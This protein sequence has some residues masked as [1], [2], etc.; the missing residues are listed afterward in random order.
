MAKT[1]P[2]SSP[3][4]GGFVGARHA[5]LIQASQHC[6]FYRDIIFRPSIAQQRLHPL[7][8]G[9]YK[10]INNVNYKYMR[11][12]IILKKIIL[13]SIILF[14]ITIR[15]NAQVF[16]G[17]DLV[18]GHTSNVEDKNI[19]W[20]SYDSTSTIQADRI[21]L[22][23]IQGLWK[24]YKGIFKYDDNVR[25]IDISKPFIFEVKDNKARRSYN[26]FIPF[27]LRKNNIVLMENR[28]MIVG[29]INKISPNEMTITWENESLHRYDR[30]FYSKK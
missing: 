7:L 30:Y 22:K 29:I 25:T 9:R 17:N 23:D 11:E 12:K 1:A 4:A 2:P 5:S 13:I 10:P 26:G 16:N 6:L 27:S 8:P 14:Q 19:N 18:P 24:A 3:L 20:E 15:L 21:E 28:N